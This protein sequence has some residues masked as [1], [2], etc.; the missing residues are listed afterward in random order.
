MHC[1]VRVV[2]ICVL[3]CMKA[4]ALLTIESMGV[5]IEHFE[6]CDVKA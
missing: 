5:N 4:R 1:C 6:A 3:G 2:A